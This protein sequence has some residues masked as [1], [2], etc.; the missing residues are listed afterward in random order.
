MS[1]K[2][3]PRAGDLRTIAVFLLLG[4][5]ATPG[6]ALDKVYE[7]TGNRVNLRASATLESEIVGVASRGDRV[8]VRR[9]VGKWAQIRP[10][11]HVS[12]WIHGAFVQDDLVT[13]A[14]LNV[15]ASPDIRAA[16]LGKIDRGQKVKV[17][18]RED[19]WLEIAAPEGIT[20]WINLPFIAEP[21]V[22]HEQY[23]AAPVAVLK[24]PPAKPVQA[25]PV[26]PVQSPQA[27][28]AS[29][30]KPPRLSLTP[31]VIPKREVN[32]PGPESTQSLGSESPRGRAAQYEG[33]VQKAAWVLRRPSEYKLVGRAGGRAHTICYLKFDSTRLEP[34][35]G[36][37][38]L[39]TGREYLVDGV[40]HSV[41]EASRVEEQP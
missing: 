14:Q 15:R 36:R 27:A 9:I 26:A 2:S 6:V 34:L 33:V 40:R 22:A 24:E 8:I 21:S 11:E 20:A 18:T 31:G 30:K 41:L 4:L 37:A 35:V 5:V 32:R 23:S 39:V 16:T 1:V 3:Q 7:V 13:A 38:V 25:V 29:A 28:H 10:P 19:D 12:F 17:R